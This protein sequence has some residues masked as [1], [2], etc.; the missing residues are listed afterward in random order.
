VLSRHPFQASGVEP[1]DRDA[2]PRVWIKFGDGPNALTILASRIEKPTVAPARHRRQLESLAKTV[3]AL[4]GRILVAGDFNDT[5]WSFGFREFVSNSGLAHM[6]RFLPS[7]PAGDHGLPQLAIDHMFASS[8]LGFEDAWLGPDIGS[9]HL[10]L[11]AR[12]TL[13]QDLAIA[14]R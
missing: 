8:S 5:P 1:G 10:P 14:L 12:V 13:P 9:D 2:P 7:F 4:D 11:L 3:Q 6:G